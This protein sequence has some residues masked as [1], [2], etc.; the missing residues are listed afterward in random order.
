MDVESFEP[1]WRQK[2][3][4]R[5]TESPFKRLRASETFVLIIE[6]SIARNTRARAIAT[7]REILPVAGKTWLS[8][9]EASKMPCIETKE[10]Q[11]RNQNRA[12]NASTPHTETTQQ[13]L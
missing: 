4:L 8:P 2:M 10:I 12:R 3:A 9:V 11:S 1:S 7:N 13:R 5:G 6:A